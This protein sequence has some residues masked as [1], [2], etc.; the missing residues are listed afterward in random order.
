MVT[1][2]PPLQYVGKNLKLTKTTNFQKKFKKTNNIKSRQNK[3]NSVDKL[4]FNLK[5][6][7]D[8]CLE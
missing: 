5:Y 4:R 1:F 8:F 7:L 6:V 2:M 3:T